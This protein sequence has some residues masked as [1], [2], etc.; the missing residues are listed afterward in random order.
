MSLQRSGP[1]QK[2]CVLAGVTLLL[3]GCLGSG[4]RPGPDAFRPG[5]IA[6][7]SVD[8][9]NQGWTEM[10][11]Y[12]AQGPGRY[13]VGSVG[14]TSREK[15]RLPES[16]AAGGAGIVLVASETGGGAEIW[17]P[18]FEVHPETSVTWTI[19]EG[20]GRSHLSVR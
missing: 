12:L 11:I 6:S 9:V 3:T 15:I 7:A 14:G 17:S 4:G 5:A 16:L 18:T 1:F 8:V 10:V 2:V 13:R 19:G 20:S